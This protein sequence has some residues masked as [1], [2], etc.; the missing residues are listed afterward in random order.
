[1]KESRCLERP[2][3]QWVLWFRI[4]VYAIAGIAYATNHCFT[5]VFPLRSVEEAHFEYLA[6]EGHLS[7][8]HYFELLAII[9]AKQPTVR[10]QSI[11]AS[12]IIEFLGPPDLVKQGNSAETYAYFYE[13]DGAKDSAV[14]LSVERDGKATIGFSN[15]SWTDF[16]DWQPVNQST[17]KRVEACKQSN[18]ARARTSPERAVGSALDSPLHILWRK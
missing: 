11:S 5:L 9:L 1:M 13:R 8:S 6:T 18:P 4:V 15:R 14:V 17:R 12:D 2:P 10:G 16:R 3:K 7:R